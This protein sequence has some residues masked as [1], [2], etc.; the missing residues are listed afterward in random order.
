MYKEYKDYRTL[1]YTSEA[2][3]GLLE[4]LIKLFE[5][6]NLDINKVSAL[7]KY[8]TYFNYVAQNEDVSIEEILQ[9]IRTFQ[10]QFGISENGL[11]PKTLKAMEWPRCGVRERLTTENASNPAKWGIRDISY[12]IRRSDSDLT[13]TVWANII[14]KSF[15]NWSNVCNLLFHK[16]DRESQANIILDIG[17]GRADDFDGPSGV[18]AWMQLCPSPNFRGQLLG[19]FD[20]GETWVENS[21]KRGIILECVA[22]HEIG[23]ALIGVHSNVSS[24]L[25]APFYSPNVCKPQKNND[26]SRA[27]NLYGTPVTTPVEPPII[28]T[29]T[30]TTP[31]T[32]GKTIIEINGTVN[33]ISIPGYRITKMG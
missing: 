1:I 15:T 3:M 8:L 11:G 14:G 10:E 21:S 17:S 26:I 23:H 29:P 30:P 22:T 32:A 9:A 2:K 28:P 24:A 27:V 19:K 25:M 16:V 31:P 33:S 4:A 18:L 20:S 13:S 5:S 12:Y 7:I 6:S